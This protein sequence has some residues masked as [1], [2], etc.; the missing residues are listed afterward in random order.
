M[1]DVTEEEPTFG[2]I[3]DIL[4][5]EAEETL[6]ILRKLCTIQFHVHYH[7]YEVM[8]TS[9]ILILTQNEFCDHHPLHVCK[10][11][12]SSSYLFVSLKYHI[13]MDH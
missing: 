5:T 10:S 9:S 1:C 12:G 3:V 2:E 6:F 4:Q 11:F 7:A 13:L 8:P